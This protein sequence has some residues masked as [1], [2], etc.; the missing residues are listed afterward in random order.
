[1]KTSSFD[2]VWWSFNLRSLLAEGWSNIVVAAKSFLSS[3]IT[4][5]TI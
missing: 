4:K 3:S 5:F 2:D 1:M